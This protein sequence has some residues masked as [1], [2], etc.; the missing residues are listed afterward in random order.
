MNTLE[1]APQPWERVP[2]VSVNAATKVDA[3]VIEL[4]LMLRLWR[5]LV[6]R[7]LAVYIGVRVNE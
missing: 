4:P 3:N 5:I 2:S 7:E 6:R 1:T